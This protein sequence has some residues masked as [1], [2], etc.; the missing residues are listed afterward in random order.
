MNTVHYRFVP[1][2]T[3]GSPGNFYGADAADTLTRLA[4]EESRA[5]ERYVEGVYGEAAR[6][7]ALRVG[8]DGVA[9]SRLEK[10]GRW[11]VR[12]EIS[13]ERFHVA[14]GDMATHEKRQNERTRE[15]RDSERS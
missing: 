6:D 8:L 9:E 11:N 3:A 5:Y 12:D 2:Y 1:R 10:Y 14:F 7:A 4:A 15:V 13:D